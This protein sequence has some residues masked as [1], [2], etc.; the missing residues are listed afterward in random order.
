MSYEYNICLSSCGGNILE[1]V[2]KNISTTFRKGI[3]SD[4]KQSFWIDSITVN[5][6]DFSI[7]QTDVG[8]FIVS[9]LNRAD[10]E[11]VFN[12]ITQ[13]MGHANI[14]FEIEEA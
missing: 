13:T 12:L 10:E 5:W 4:D 2:A 9:N 11:V 14:Q 3:L 1:E 6:I 7:E 8:F